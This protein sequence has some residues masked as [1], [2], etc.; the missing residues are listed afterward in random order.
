MRHYP[1]SSAIIIMLRSLQMYG[2]TQVVIDLMAQGAPT[3]EAAVPI[4]S[5]VHK[6]ELTEREVRSIAYHM[7]SP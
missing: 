3:F 7:N 4:L 6:A 1:A 5:L 2:L